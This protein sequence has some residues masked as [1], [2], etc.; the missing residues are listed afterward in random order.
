[1]GP[2]TYSPLEFFSRKWIASVTSENFVHMP[3]NAEHHIQKI[4]PGPPRAIAPATPA[5]LPV[6]TV[7]ARAVQ[8]AWK[9]LMEPSFACVLSKILPTVFFMA[10]PNLRIW[11][12]LVRTDK[13]RPTPIIHIIA[14]TPQMK[15][16]T[17]WLMLAIFSAIF[18]VPFCWL[19]CIQHFISLQC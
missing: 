9:G 13:R 17:T 14:G 16:L 18:T 10:T 7:P 8:T 5:I 12:N 6:P 15:P 1:M 19:F 4:A 3:R 11:M 2:P